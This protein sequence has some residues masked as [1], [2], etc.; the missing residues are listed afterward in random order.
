MTSVRLEAGPAEGVR[1]LTLDE[2]GKRN[3]LSA[4]V[5][6]GLTDAV[7]AVAEDA[8]ARVLVVTGN[9]PAFCAGADLPA[10][11]GQVD[12]PV[13]EVRDRLLDVYESFLRIGRLP[14]LTIAAVNGPAIG[15]GLNLAFCCDLR[16]AAPAATFG[17]TFTKLGL[18]PGGG[19]TSF[20]VRA[21]GRQRALA[22]ILDGG[23]LGA[24]EA[25]ELGIVLR[26]ETDPLAAAM[27]LAERHAHLPRALLGAIKRTVGLA[28]EADLGTV[29]EA[30]SWAQAASV[31]TS[32][33]LRAAV[34]R[35]GTRN[36][37]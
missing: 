29:V 22:L 31:V 11:F 10:T 27:E 4:G 16:I 20:L 6:A 17:V 1:V 8:G 33:E 18:H 2:P 37:G 19:C 35:Y 32:P 3:A 21:L 12:R 34:A 23:T 15:A 13:A 26:I 24:D 9:G 5:V 14:I 30:E 25:L 28:T 36:P 7:R